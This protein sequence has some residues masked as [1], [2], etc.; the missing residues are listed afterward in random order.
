MTFVGEGYS[1]V[2][3]PP[4]GKGVGRRGSSG[5]RKFGFSDFKIRKKG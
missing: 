4:R 1:T 5:F 3:I 2:S